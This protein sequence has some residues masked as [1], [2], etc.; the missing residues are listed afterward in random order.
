MID[1]IPVNV[2][3]IHGVKRVGWTDVIKVDFGF[4]V[5]LITKIDEVSFVPQYCEKYHCGY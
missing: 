3:K 5:S 1:C 2:M 4:V